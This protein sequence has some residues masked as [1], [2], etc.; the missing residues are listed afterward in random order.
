[1][2]PILEPPAPTP[3]T[4]LAALF[5]GGM[6]AV[7]LGVSAVSGHSLWFRDAGAAARGIDVW[8]DPAAGLALAAFAVAGSIALE[9]A[10]A[11]ARRVGQ[12]LA[13]LL[14]PL[15][16][17]QCVLLAV[18]SGV[19]EE[20]LFRGAL[21]PLVGWFWA[22]LIFGLA[23]L[24]PQRELWPWTLF[25]VLAGFALGGLYE[26]TGNLVAPVVAHF[27]INA[28]NLRRLTRRYVAED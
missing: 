5:Y 26:W 23:H 27:G 8:R 21:Q 7:A 16:V 6:F 20:A 12:A 9:G 3:L 1:M 10:T 18:L 13:E 15:T 4:R 2:N 11:W 28:I 14:G 22:S 17:G 24:A 19:A 25:T